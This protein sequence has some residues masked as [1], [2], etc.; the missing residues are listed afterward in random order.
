MSE[1]LKKLNE[2]SI[3]P[4]EFYF[5]INDGYESDE[6]KLFENEIGDYDIVEEVG[7]REG[8]GEHFHFVVYMKKYDTYLKA[9]GYYT[10]HEGTDL[11]DSK[12]EVVTPVERKVVFYESIK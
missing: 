2:L 9:I 6:V 7:G 11:E 12:W 1:L 4:Y 10:S 3:T 8:K 5:N